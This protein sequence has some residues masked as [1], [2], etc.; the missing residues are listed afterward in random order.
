MVAKGEIMDRIREREP[1]KLSVLLKSS[2]AKYKE[3]RRVYELI[4][5]GAIELTSAKDE[6]IPDGLREHMYV[7]KRGNNAT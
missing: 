1:V 7:F 6:D 3:R 4:D 5:T 2:Q